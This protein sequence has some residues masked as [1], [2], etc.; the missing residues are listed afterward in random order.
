MSEAIL[1]E[2]TVTVVGTDAKI[3]RVCTWMMRVALPSGVHVE[4]SQDYVTGAV[5][6]RE[7]GAK[8]PSVWIRSVGALLDLLAGKRSLTGSDGRMD[9][10]VGTEV[11]PP[12]VPP[13]D[14]ADVSM[15]VKIDNRRWNSADEERLRKA[16]VALG[17][18]HPYELVRA[19]VD[20]DR[21]EMWQR[22][23]DELEQTQSPSEVSFLVAKWRGR[24]LG[25]E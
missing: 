10:L 14:H 9:V 6:L 3:D 11:N 15:S 7:V 17:S 16:M 4:M 13:R 21:Y 23:A 18:T 24:S 19:F 5:E 8:L 12:V 1:P 20:R 22:A 2:G 25:E